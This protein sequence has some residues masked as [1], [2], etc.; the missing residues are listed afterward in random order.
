MSKVAIDQT[1]HHI[2]CRTLQPDGSVTDDLPYKSGTACSDC[3]SGVACI[4]GLCVQSSGFFLLWSFDKQSFKNRCLFAEFDSIKFF[5]RSMNNLILICDNFCIIL[6]ENPRDICNCFL[7]CFLCD[8]SSV[9]GNIRWETASRVVKPSMPVL[10]I[11]ETKM[12]ISF[13]RCCIV[14]KKNLNL[15]SVVFAN[16]LKKNLNLFSVVFANIPEFCDFCH[17]KT[18]SL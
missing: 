11:K 10:C 14:R 9:Y 18:V 12:R 4:N 3:G 2:R 5:L 6:Q 16:I 8:K 7:N 15:F 13:Q 17:T 1:C